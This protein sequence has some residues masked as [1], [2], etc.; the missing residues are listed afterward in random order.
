MLMTRRSD[1]NM[2]AALCVRVLSLRVVG[3]PDLAAGRTR[4]ARQQRGSRLAWGKQ[5]ALLVVVDEPLVQGR[6]DLLGVLL[7]DPGLHRGVHS[8]RCVVTLLLAPTTP[9]LIGVTLI[10]IVWA[11][12]AASVLFVAASSTA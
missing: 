3:V 6:A 7:A 9:S 10:V 11:L 5:R 8:A 2:R 12:A 4:Q 1:P